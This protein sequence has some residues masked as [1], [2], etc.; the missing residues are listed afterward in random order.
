[1][2]RGWGETRWTGSRLDR[3]PIAAHVI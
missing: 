1:M 2:R 3:I